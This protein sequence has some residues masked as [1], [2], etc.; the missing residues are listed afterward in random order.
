M[1]VFL[2]TLTIV[3]DLIVPVR[4]KIPVFNNFMSYL[5]VD[6]FPV[7]PTVLSCNC[8]KSS[9]LDK[10]FILTGNLKVINNNRLRKIICKS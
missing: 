8:D 4:S 7:D 10:V 5:D 3:Y 2:L 6:E 9:F 1:K